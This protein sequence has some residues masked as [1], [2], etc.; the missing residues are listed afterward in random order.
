MELGGELSL[1][2]GLKLTGSYTYSD[3]RYVHYSF[4][5]DTVRTF[6]LDGRALPGVPRNWGHLA[7]RVSPALARGGW[8]EVE[9]THSSSY[10]V[11]D[12][13]A[14]RRTSPWWVTN[15]RL[16]REGGGVSPFVAVSN[17]F[18]R[19]YVGSV[20][21]NAAGGRYYEPAPGRS[22]Y[23]GVSVAAER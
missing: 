12:T 11:D 13:L 10:Y 4:R 23:F 15:L 5:P 3:L 20:V 9:T 16:G 6:V 8:A 1:A 19:L 22:V 2:P 14:T 17:V 21:I 18:N 7:L